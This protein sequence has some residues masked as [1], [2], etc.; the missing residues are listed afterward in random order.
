MDE[1]HLFNAIRYVTL[2]PVRAG[3]VK[4]AM[5]L[6]MGLGMVKRRSPPGRR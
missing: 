1:T 2:N 3:L 4:H 6:V 5:A